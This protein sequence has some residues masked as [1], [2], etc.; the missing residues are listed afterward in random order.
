MN[1]ENW[2]TESILTED[3]RMQRIRYANLINY[4]R[5]TSLKPYQIAHTLHLMQNVS[6]TLFSDG[7]ATPPHTIN[8]AVN[9]ICNLRCEYCDL[10]YGRKNSNIHN[11]KID[12]GVIDSHK[13]CE[14]PL[15]T[16]KRIIDEVAWFKPT[17]RTPWM[18]PL[19]YQ[20]IFNLIEYVKEKSLDFSMLTNGLLLK[21]YAEKLAQ[22]H[23]DALRISLDGP[24]NV[25][26]GLCG[27]KGAY[28]LAIDGMKHIVQR[29]KEGMCGTILDCYFTLTDKNYMNL[30][31]MMESIEKEGLLEH[32]GVGFYMFN[33]ISKHQV[34]KHNKEHRNIS[35]VSIHE[36]SAKYVNLSNIVIDKVIE[37]KEIIQKRYKGA[38]V[39]FRPDF[40]REN[41]IHCLQDN[42]L[43]LP[44]SRCDVLSHVL[45]INPDGI[46]KS[47][48]QCI[49]PPV[50]NIYKN[51]IME[52][53]NGKI[54]REQ[55][56]LMK[57]H[58]LFHGC[59]RC[60]CAYYGLE[61]SQNTWKDRQKNHKD[62][63]N[64][65]KL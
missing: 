34:K 3:E 29:K 24:E 55:R 17:I 15:E 64:S 2:L 32:M 43:S 39:F 31:D 27:I 20:D 23:V 53:W 45:Y 13:K 56:G 21:K 16:C 46:V 30:V 22:L 26:D 9:N 19:L 59:T 58:G 7:Y 36:A 8:L 54:M 11:D 12:F 62:T 61:D 33:Y 25:H 44:G 49:L 4:L 60:W 37:Q 14:L 1:P 51:S 28:R 35:G 57:E 38:M 5:T 63:Q 6:F 65:R 41:L 48:P 50:G 10:Y 47:F 42:D 40:N 18:E 52:I